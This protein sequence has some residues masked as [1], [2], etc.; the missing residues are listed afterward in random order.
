MPP[1]DF[2][3]TTYWRAHRA[4]LQESLWQGRAGI[5]IS[6]AG[7]KRLREIGVP[8][9]IGA[10]EAGEGEHPGGWRRALVPIESLTHVERE[11]LSLGAQVE[12]V[13]P[14]LS[15]GSGSRRRR[16]PWRRST[17]EDDDGGAGGALRPSRPRRRR[18]RST[19]EG[20]DRRRGSPS[21]TQSPGPL[22]E[23][24][25]IGDEGHK[26]LDAHGDAM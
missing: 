20:N 2:D 5:R 17:A 15:C 26:A 3:P 13:S 1:A 12:A 6:Q 21:R 7:T 24:P 11:L 4:Q 9:V 8:A 22:T 19:A 18:R 16:W 25:G 14:P 23:P 10:V